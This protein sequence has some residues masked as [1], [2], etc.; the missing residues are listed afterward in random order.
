MTAFA[1]PNKIGEVR[2]GEGGYVEVL[3]KDDVRVE[4]MAAVMVAVTSTAKEMGWSP[5]RL[6]REYDALIRGQRLIAPSSPASSSQAG[7]N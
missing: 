5:G 4:E 7:L 1:D 3:F 6:F 2:R